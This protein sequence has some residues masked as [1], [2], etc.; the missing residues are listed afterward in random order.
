[1]H[2]Y[3]LIPIFILPVLIIYIILLF[4]KLL[5]LN[6]KNSKIFLNCLLSL[7]RVKKKTKI[8]LKITI[9]AKKLHAQSILQLV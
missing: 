6:R 2:I 7:A 9:F 4:Y 8:L 3:I 1:M 5:I